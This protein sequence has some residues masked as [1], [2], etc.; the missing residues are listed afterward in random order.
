MGD[1]VR[2]EAGTT[3]LIQRV[4]VGRVNPYVLSVL[5]LGERDAQEFLADPDAVVHHWR[6]NPRTR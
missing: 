4:G 1:L 3:Y 6:W 5:K 2:T